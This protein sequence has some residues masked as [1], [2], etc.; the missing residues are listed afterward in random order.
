MDEADGAGA[1]VGSAVLTVDAA[2][3]AVITLTGEIDMS[4]VETLRGAIEPMLGEPRERVDFDLAALDFMDSSGI[5]F[6]LRVA[7]KAGSV[8]LRSP[9]AL[10]RRM[11]QATGLTDVLLM[12]P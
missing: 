11:V 3:I 8:H 5:A 7:A 1:S 10:V 9:S 4:N 2:G 12:D 6:L